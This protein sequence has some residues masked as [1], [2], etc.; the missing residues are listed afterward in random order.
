MSICL[1]IVIELRLSMLMIFFYSCARVGK[2][3]VDRLVM[4]IC[5]WDNTKIKINF[6]KQVKKHVGFYQTRYL[7]GFFN[8]TK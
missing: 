3:L 7:T 5:A 1:H 2:A 6:I 8:L 4:P